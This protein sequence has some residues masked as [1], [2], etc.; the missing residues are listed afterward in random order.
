MLIGA[1]A[2]ANAATSRKL[3][4]PLMA[5]AKCGNLA[6]MRMLLDAGADSEVNWDF[7]CMLQNPRP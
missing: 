6:V 1:G 2:D 3:W 7:G 4:K 5:A